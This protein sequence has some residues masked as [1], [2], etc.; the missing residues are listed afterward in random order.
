MKNLEKAIIIAIIIF[1]LLNLLY[2]GI[3]VR[4]IIVSE[5]NQKTL[6]LGQGEILG[7]LADQD[8]YVIKEEIK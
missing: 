1:L 6:M 2:I 3:I 8:G 4:H 5:K 7:I